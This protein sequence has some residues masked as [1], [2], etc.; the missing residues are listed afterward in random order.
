LKHNAIRFGLEAI[1]N[2]GGSLVEAIV[3]ERRR[4][5][6]ASFMT[7]SSGLTANW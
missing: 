7:L 3:D 5:L 6:F 2:V 4:G 1:R